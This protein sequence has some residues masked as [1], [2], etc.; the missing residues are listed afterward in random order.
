MADTSD[1]EKANNLLAAGAVLA[2]LSN[3][4]FGTLR[5]VEAVIDA[6]GNVTN[7]IAVTFSFL[8]SLYRITVERIP[9]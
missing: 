2:V 3:S 7:E 4:D 5:T 8:R 9:D 6:D 1:D